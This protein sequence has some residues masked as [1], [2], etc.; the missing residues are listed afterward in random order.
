MSIRIAGGKSR[1]LNVSA[2]THGDAVA[3]LADQAV[4]VVLVHFELIRQTALGELV[5]A[6]ADDQHFLGA[7]RGSI[8][9]VRLET[10]HEN[11][12]VARELEARPAERAEHLVF[13]FLEKAEKVAEPDDASGVG[14]GPVHANVDPVEIRHPLNLNPSIHLC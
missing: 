7:G 3:A 9:A 11:A 14:V 1:G 10:G 8:A 5:H 2:L 13:R 4:Q 6:D 12:E